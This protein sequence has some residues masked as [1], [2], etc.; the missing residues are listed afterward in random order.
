MIINFLKMHKFIWLVLNFSDLSLELSEVIFVHH[1]LHV[2]RLVANKAQ[3]KKKK[4][5]ASF[6]LN[7]HGRA[8][9]FYFY[10]SLFF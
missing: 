4:C 6:L 1:W 7:V 5:L 2:D 8:G 10:F 3:I 9:G